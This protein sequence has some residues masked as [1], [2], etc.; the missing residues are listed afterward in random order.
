[1]K[2]KRRSPIPKKGQVINVYDDLKNCVRAAVVTTH[3]VEDPNLG[4]VFDIRFLDN[5]MTNS[6]YWSKFRQS[7][8]KMHLGGQMP[9]QTKEHSAIYEE[10]CDV[11]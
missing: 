9:V 7:W 1:M 3:V 11:A 8:S 10:E 6:A 5:K 4:P 2:E